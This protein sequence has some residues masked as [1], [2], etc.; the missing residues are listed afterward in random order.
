[1]SPRW[2]AM[3]HLPEHVT[4]D[5][6]AVLLVHGWGGF[7]EGWGP[8]VDAL[9]LAGLRSVAVD[10]P[11]WGA[12][13]APRGFAH[14]PAD[15]AAALAGSIDRHRPVAL[16]GHSMG[17]G[18]ALLA[19]RDRG[20]AGLVAIGPQWSPAG[21]RALRSWRGV[22]RLPVVGATLMRIG[23]AHARRNRS[24]I[25]DSFLSAIAR[26][27]AEIRDPRLRDLLEEA[28]DRFAATDTRT[29]ARSVAPLLGF[30]ARPVARDVD[31]DTL[32]ILGAED[33]VIDNR[34]A[35]WAIA[36]APRVRSIVIPDVAHFPHF[37]APEQALPAIVD[38]LRSVARATPAG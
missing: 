18:P 27:D 32:L 11:G 37:E 17:S 5:G 31:S 36:P 7:K 13:P 4:G 38:H 12:A 1:M 14:G 20:I 21:T 33:R 6:P 23:L 34:A 15:Y 2:D 30:D 3:N 8:L 25:R 24:A 10:L 26:P 19:A 29:L 9:A 22:A 35:R 16:V 28:T